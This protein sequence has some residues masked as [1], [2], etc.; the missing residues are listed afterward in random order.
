MATEVDSSLPAPQSKREKELAATRKLI[1]QAGDLLDAVDQS[2]F[3]K[4]NERRKYPRFDRN[5]IPFGPVLGVG[6]FG[7]VFEVGR[8]ALK[9]P[10][11]VDVQVHGQGI[12]KEEACAGTGDGECEQI[13]IVE[14][15]KQEISCRDGSAQP[16]EKITCS[17]S[18]TATTS[19]AAPADDINQSP[20]NSLKISGLISDDDI[21]YQVTTARQYMCD[22]AR[23]NGDAR[24]AEKRLHRDLCDLDRARGMID[25]AIEA[26]LLS[27]LWHPNIGKLLVM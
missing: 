18:Q 12:S 5:E 13:A 21:H 14:D 7:I 25:L 15:V 27:T 10:E 11:E 1:G 4:E 8:F 16:T 19:T 9:I 3:M 2:Y 22:H 20:P 23:R 17:D 6:G 26:K 24:Y